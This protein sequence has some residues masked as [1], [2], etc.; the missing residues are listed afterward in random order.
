MGRPPSL[1]LRGTAYYIRRSRY[2]L[3]ILQ[4][5]IAIVSREH[6]GVAIVA[7][8][9]ASLDR[10]AFGALQIDRASSLEPPV[11]AR[12]HAVWLQVSCA[13]IP[14]RNATNCHARYRTTLSATPRRAA[15]N[16]DVVLQIGRLHLQ[17][18]RRCRAD[19]R[20]VVPA[21]RPKQPNRRIESDL[22][23]SRP[24]MRPAPCYRL[25]Q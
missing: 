1:N 20:V 19:R 18:L 13:G 15:H 11:A 3:N 24:E 4:E 12:W 9:E 6:D 14:D 17:I 7:R 5:G 23:Q 2:R 21:H 8:E 22:H 16:R 10:H 25:A